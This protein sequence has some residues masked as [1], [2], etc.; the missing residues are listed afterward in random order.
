MAGGDVTAD[1]ARKDAGRWDRWALRYD[2]GWRAKTF[3]RPLYAKI[4][5]TLE[6][7]SGRHLLD[8]GAGTGTVVAGAIARGARA[9]GVDASVG[10]VEVAE[11]KAPGRFVVAAAEALPFPDASFDAVTSSMSMHHWGSAR[12]G[13]AEVGR[14]LRPG[15]TA[16]IVDGELRG[17]FR[18]VGAL[19]HLV[20]RRRAHYVSRDEVAA[21]LRS[22]GLEPVG[23]IS[24]RKR[25]LMTLA[26]RAR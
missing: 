5:G 4:L 8:V 3:F 14:V 18:L 1:V 7:L 10:M 26:E 15:G 16:L 19:F 9:V 25:V 23:R 22:A 13:L 11:G 21:L 20:N 6:P 2:R 24:Y 12:S 17:L